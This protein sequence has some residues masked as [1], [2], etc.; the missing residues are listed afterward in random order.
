M[1]YSHNITAFALSL[2]FDLALIRF[3]VRPFKLR[4]FKLL[5]TPSPHDHLPRLPFFCIL[6]EQSR[7]FLLGA[8][9]HNKRRLLLHRVRVL[10]LP[11]CRLFLRGTDDGETMPVAESLC[12]RLCFRG[13]HAEAPRQY[14]K[15][16]DYIK[17][18]QMQIVGF[19]REITLID[20]GITNDPEKFVTEICIPVK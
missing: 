15:L 17:K 1:T 4:P 18:H 10:Q 8:E 19:S 13:S 14:K 9:Q 6:S 7:R 11:F 2:T 12:V 20:Y 5:R 16:L 3:K